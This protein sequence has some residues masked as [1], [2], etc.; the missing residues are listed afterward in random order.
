MNHKLRNVA[1]ALAL[2]LPVALTSCSSGSSTD[3]KSGSDK[4]G[5]KP[6][7]GQAPAVVVTPAANATRLPVTTEIGTDVANGTV[8]AITLTNAAGQ[9][10]SGA[11]R[12]DGSSWVPSQP[13]SFGQ[14]YTAKVTAVGGNGAVTE[15]TTQFT[16][17]AKPSTRPIRTSV[18]VS[19]DQKYGVGMP[20]VVDFGAAVPDKDKA[21]V[22][23][24]LFVRS[25]P[26]QI[27][28]WRWYS[29]SEVTY[30]PEIYWKTGTTVDLHLA[31]G[32]LPIG[33]RVIDKDRAATFEI[34]RDMQYKVTDH[35]HMMTI[36]KNGKVIKKYPI[37]MGKPS[38]PSWSGK[39]VIMNRL[40]A[41]IFDTLD[42]PNGYRV[43]VKYAERLTWSGTFLHSAP[44]SVGAQGH[45]N[46]SHG[47]VNL[48]PSSARW[49]Y[50]NSL[51]GDP[52][53]IS[54]TPVHAAQ[55]NGWTVWDM[56]WASYLKGSALKS[57]IAPQPR[58]AMPAI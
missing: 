26:T 29:D 22:E 23:R 15:K 1:V 43:A 2:A 34:G 6:G 8:T 9:A 36:T 42:Q 4:E 20:I 11:M 3:S 41:T 51:V 46:V 33:G 13:L 14:T 24:R 18:N 48:A 47:C 57:P 12:Y 38:T 50:Q 25:Y 39:F 10:V 28:A 5:S 7:A 27:G 16:T 19:S 58:A 54:G 45:T 52:V 31:L 32:G 40:P 55:G 53:S 35:N 21:A 49:I 44:W 56:S 30:R 37:S 17:M